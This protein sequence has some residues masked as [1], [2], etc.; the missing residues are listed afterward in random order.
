MG[1]KFSVIVPVYN[2]KNY[3]SKCIKSIISQSYSNIQ[4]III[5]DGSTDSSGAIC[6][7]YCTDSRVEVIHRDNGGLSAARNEGIKYV[8]G[9]YILFIDSDDYIEEDSLLEI[10]KVLNENA[11]DILACNAFIENTKIKK[12]MKREYRYSPT[13]LDGIS[14][15][16]KEVH[17]NVLQLSACINI[18][19]AEFWK[20]NG[21][22]F[23]EGIYHED[24]Q[25]IPKVLLSADSVLYYST[26]FY[27]YVQ[28]KG[29]ITVSPEYETERQRDVVQVMKEWENMADRCDDVE[30]GELIRGMICKCYIYSCALNN[31]V[32]VRSLKFSPSYLI[33]NSLNIKEK[34]KAVF[35]ILTP[36]V[37]I[38]IFNL[39]WKRI[40]G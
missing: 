13:V 32:D 7:S 27:H 20:K 16:K 37:Y 17:N 12:L 23:K 19:K 22:I 11:V 8:H 40:H 14:F 38:Y 26:P 15:Y 31:E 9:D 21:F 2:V 36:R 30:L 33:C 18:Y 39:K 29:S 28:R 4:I 34:I 5:D 1:V 25:L 35:F 6:D 3:I 10:A 24:L